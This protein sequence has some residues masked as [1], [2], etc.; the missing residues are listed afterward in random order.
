MRPAL[1]EN[2][3]SSR[4]LKWQTAWALSSRLEGIVPQKF[5]SVSP[6]L[7]TFRG[8]QPHPR[9]TPGLCGTYQGTLGVFSPPPAFLV[10]LSGGDTESIAS[11]NFSVLSLDDLI[12]EFAAVAFL[13]YYSVVGPSGVFC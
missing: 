3:C 5:E 11:G 13:I 4:T 8:Q 1:S 10:G 2:A 12:P 9:V 7:P 6:L